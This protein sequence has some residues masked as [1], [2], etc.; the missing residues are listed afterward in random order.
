MGW[1]QDAH[2]AYENEL[3]AAERHMEGMEPPELPEM[4][5][6]CRHFVPLG[7]DDNAEILRCIPY[8]IPGRNQLAR[9][10]S[11]S[12]GV[13]RQAVAGDDRFLGVLYARD[14]PCDEWEEREE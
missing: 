13:C 7:V 12:L 2:V 14:N 8:E 3:R 9:H 5:H 10:L 11:L 4:C 6:T 1:E